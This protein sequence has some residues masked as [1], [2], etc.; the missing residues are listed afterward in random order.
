METTT[1]KNVCAENNIEYVET[2]SKQRDL[3]KNEYYALMVTDS[4]SSPHT[5]GLDT[6]SGKYLVGV[7]RPN[8][9]MGCYISKSFRKRNDWH[10]GKTIIVKVND[11]SNYTLL[12][13]ERP[14]TD[15][16]TKSTFNLFE[17]YLNELYSD[18]Y[19]EQEAIDNFCYMR[20]G[21]IWESLI[22]KHFTNHEL[23][24]LLRK[25]DPIAFNTMFN[26]SHYR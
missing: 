4:S 20:E 10:R 13:M 7:E 9:S 16:R 19:S 22:R 15:T 18:T 23:G 14:L 5:K 12:E 24:N 17:D 26:E 1:Y 8:E 3:N 11:I 25:Y 21:K 2:V 6:L